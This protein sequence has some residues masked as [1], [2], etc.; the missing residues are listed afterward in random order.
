MVSDAGISGGPVDFEVVSKGNL[1]LY[2]CLSVNRG[3][4][5]R[6]ATLEDIVIWQMAVILAASVIGFSLSGVAGFGGGVLVLPVLVW[7]YGPEVA[8]PVVAVFQLIGT[9]TRVWLN[10]EFM[11]WKVAAWFAAGSIPFAL[12]GSFL[13]ISAD[14]EL[15]TRIMGG[16]M[17]ALVVLTQLPWS[18]R[19]RMTLWGFLPL[20]AT[21]GFLASVMGIPGPFAPVFYMAY[22]MKPREYMAT[23]SLGMFLIQL[24]KLAVYGGAELLTPL[25]A[26]LGLA[27][28]A[29]AMG[30]AY[31]GARVLR[32]LPDKVFATGINIIVVAFGALFL[33]TGG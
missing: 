18:K 28:G 8:V 7:V 22:G 2:D 26:S 27:L 9:A 31:F 3:S 24:P 29:I 19:V 1:A 25:V 33:L 13:F 5:R 10:R 12:L 30:G 20:G 16:G 4:S 32:R 6:K 15:L 17:I 14:T 11:N 21:A 23:F